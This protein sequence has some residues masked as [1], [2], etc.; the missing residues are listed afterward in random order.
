MSEKKHFP[1]FGRKVSEHCRA[2]LSSAPSVHRN[3][4]RA[5]SCTGTDI[6]AVKPRSLQM[7]EGNKEKKPSYSLSSPEFEFV[8]SNSTTIFA[9]YL[10]WTFE[11]EQAENQCQPIS[12]CN[13][14]KITEVV[15][16][17]LLKVG[18]LIWISNIYFNINIHLYSNSCT[19]K[20]LT[21]CEKLWRLR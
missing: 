3:G 13:W 11:L 4:S 18:K 14:E 2:V 5:P 21:N 20:E 7:S 6:S 1:L 10:Y 12:F 8:F 15:F 17:P 16:V 9:P 19:W